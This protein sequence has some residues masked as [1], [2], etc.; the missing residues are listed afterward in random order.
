M[1]LKELLKI[2][3]DILS[4]DV[5]ESYFEATEQPDSAILKRLVRCFEFVY[6]EVY[7]DY[8]NA[9]RKT[10]VEVKDGKAC[11]D[12]LR[13]CK[14]LSLTDSSGNDVNFRYGDGTL[15]VE[16]DGKYN[17][18]YAH[19]P[20]TPA[21]DEEVT[22]PPNIGERALTYGVLREYLSALN[23]W[24]NAKQ[25]DD[26]FKNALQAACGKTSLARMPKRGWS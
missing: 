26:R 22:L 17:M 11:V 9:L 1:K 10:V 4:L 20:E 25:W 2:C 12:G 18:R 19:L 15:S 3:C 14:V 24:Y 23:D 21:W 16:R 7:R 5:A 13:L 8:A 6:E